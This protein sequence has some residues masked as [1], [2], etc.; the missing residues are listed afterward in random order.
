[1]HISVFAKAQNTTEY[2]QIQAIVLESQNLETGEAFGTAERGCALPD[3]SMT[4]R[5]IDLSGVRLTAARAKA[6]A[7]EA[8]LLPLRVIWVL[9]RSG[10]NREAL[11]GWKWSPCRVARMITSLQKD[12]DG[13]KKPDKR[14]LL[15]WGDLPPL[16]SL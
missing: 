4:E 6:L 3:H 8:L 7:W 10:R 12:Q 2:T 5:N 1:M 14:L 15:A 16:F 9:R 13:V 11:R